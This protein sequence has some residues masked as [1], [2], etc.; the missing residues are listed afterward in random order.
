WNEGAP[1]QHGGQQAKIGEE[2]PGRVFTYPAGQTEMQPGGLVWT[3]RSACRFRARFYGAPNHLT[4]PLALLA[5]EHQAWRG[6]HGGAEP[7]DRL[8]ELDVLHQLDGGIEVEERH[9]PAIERAR[10]FPALGLS[11]F[12]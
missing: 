2:H 11:Q 5:I 1:D 12:V 10:F 8:C 3:G 6:H 9:E 7:G 4:D